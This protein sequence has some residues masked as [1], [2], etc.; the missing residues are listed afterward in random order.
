MDAPK[1]Q[2]LGQTTED[3]Q[4]QH[5]E[6]AQ[7]NL[8]EPDKYWSHQTEDSTTAVTSQVAEMP[9]TG[10]RRMV[11]SLEMDVTSEKPAGQF[12]HRPQGVE[13]R[14]ARRWN[15]SMRSCCPW[16]QTGPDPGRGQ[17]LA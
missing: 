14:H 12:E 13:A 1:S 2:D 9:L 11:R 16:S 6:L 5:H 17:R 10:L 8:E 4:A 15:R 3:T 7:K